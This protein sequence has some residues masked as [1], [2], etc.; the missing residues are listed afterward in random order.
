MCHNKADSSVTKPHMD[1][2]RRTDS[3]CHTRNANK[4]RSGHIVRSNGIRN[5]VDAITATNWFRRND[6]KRNI[7]YGA[8]KLINRSDSRQEELQAA[9][10]KIKLTP[11]RTLSDYVIKYSIL[12]KYT[13]KAG[14]PE[15][16]S[17][18]DNE[19]I[20]VQCILVGLED[21]NAVSISSNICG[22]SSQ[23]ASQRNRRGGEN[24]D[25][26]GTSQA[27]NKPRQRKYQ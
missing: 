10:K 25:R 1:I 26:A 5:R 24:D 12:Q 6:G 2:T 19:N 15:I 8:K 17:E 9:A 3:R 16:V 21:N 4:G 11:G 14:C 13:H 7:G 27:N 23:T 22:N 18:R 20:T